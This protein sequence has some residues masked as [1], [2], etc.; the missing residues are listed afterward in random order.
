MGS[1][2]LEFFFWKKKKKSARKGETTTLPVV[3]TTTL[4]ARGFS[5]LVISRVPGDS[6]SGNFV[7]KYRN[8]CLPSGI[9]LSNKMRVSNLSERTLAHIEGIYFLSMPMTPSCL[10]SCSLNP[11]PLWTETSISL[12]VIQKTLEKVPSLLSPTQGLCVQGNPA[13]LDINGKHFKEYW[14][15]TVF[16]EIMTRSSAS[17]TSFCKQIA[18]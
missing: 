12:G 18:L 17:M 5:L 4:P 15:L 3:E 16:S 2:G 7:S 10:T 9:K 8:N 11:D 1:L 13:T 14:K 6:L